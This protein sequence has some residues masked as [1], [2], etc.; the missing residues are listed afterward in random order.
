MPGVTSLPP[1][2]AWVKPHN[3][4]R[5]GRDRYGQQTNEMP[6]PVLMLHG[7]GG[8][9]WEWVVWRR[10]F[11][12][13]G[14]V[15]IARD[16]LPSPEGLAAT[17]LADYSH[18]VRSQLEHMDRPRIVV[19]ASLGGLLAWMNADLADALVLV[20]PLPAAPWHVDLPA[21]AGSPAI[22]AWGSEASLSGTRRSLP[23]ADEAA[24][25]FAFRH[26]RDE[27]GTVL[28]AA[29][30]GVVAPKPACP[31]VMVISGAD[32]DVPASLSNAVADALGARTIFLPQASHVGPLLGKRAAE[33]AGE[34][35]A[36]LNG[37]F[38]RGTS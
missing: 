5:V 19:G 30:A 12:A 3:H 37:L 2:V 9:A 14:L 10:V 33:A 15:T 29:I 35:V 1:R 27:S 32:D 21:R 13:A 26:W 36:V 23:D 34:A 25:L 20:N 4:D 17:R 31:V 38:P 22:I 11:E 18:Q 8:G 16:L 28:D 24:C 6:V 7:A